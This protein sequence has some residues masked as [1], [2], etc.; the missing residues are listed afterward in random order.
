MKEKLKNIFKKAARSPITAAVLLSLVLLLLFFPEIS[1]I[2]GATFYAPMQ[3]VIKFLKFLRTFIIA[4]AVPCLAIYVCIKA[5]PCCISLFRQLRALRKVK[6]ILKENKLKYDIKHSLYYAGRLTFGIKTKV[7]AHREDV[8]IVTVPTRRKYAKYH[9]ADPQRIEIWVKK[10]MA[11]GGR[12]RASVVEIAGLTQKGSI[13]LPKW[14]NG[15]NYLVF[16]RKPMEI[17]SSEHSDFKFKISGD[18]I[19]STFEVYTLDEIS[20]ITFD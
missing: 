9:F 8:N 7:R 3:A 12:Y 13:M 11:A 10:Y 4:V 17:T 2:F 20:K 14:E 18:K 19:F 15:K 5:I 16:D 1:L 6:R